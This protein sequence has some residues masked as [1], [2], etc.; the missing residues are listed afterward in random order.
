MPVR[1]QDKI[2]RKILENFWAC[3]KPND[4]C[5]LSI[6]FKFQNKMPACLNQISLYTLTSP[7]WIENPSK[8]GLI[9]ISQPYNAPNLLSSSII[10][11]NVHSQFRSKYF[12]ETKSFLLSML[13]PHERNYSMSCAKV[14][15]KMHWWYILLAD[16]YYWTL[17][18]KLSSKVAT[19]NCG[20]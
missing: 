20:K 4:H 2:L 16:L 13:L 18:F 10:S 9:C 6:I 17:L 12:F 14:L 7:K 19:L 15:I 5:R 3:S 1:Q 8:M 11:G